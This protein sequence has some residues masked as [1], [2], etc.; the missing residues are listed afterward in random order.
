MS[1][2][3]KELTIGDFAEINI[4]VPC[5]KKQRIKELIENMFDLADV[6]YSV[7]DKADDGSISLEEMFPDLHAGS[8]IRGLRYREGMTQAQLAEK[9]GVRARHVSEMENGRRVIDKETAKRLAEVLN[10]TLLFSDNLF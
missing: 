5:D 3:T 6:L 10:T 7:R 8:A 9:I 2:P 4:R 1:E